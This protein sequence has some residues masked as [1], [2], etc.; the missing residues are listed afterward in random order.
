MTRRL[1]TVASAIFILLG[2]FVITAGL[3]LMALAPEASLLYYLAG[4]AT[5][6]LLGA[7]VGYP[8]SLLL[9]ILYRSRYP[10]EGAVRRRYLAGLTRLHRQARIVSLEGLPNQPQP[11]MEQLY[12]RLNDNFSELL[13]REAEGIFFHTAISQSGRLDGL[14][15]LRV[16]LRLVKKL[17]R[18]YHP[19]ARW[20]V[21]PALYVHVLDAALTPTRA[22]EIDYSAQIGPAIVG[23]SVVGA[24]PGGGLVSNIIAD[25]VI[26][27]SANALMTLRIGLLTRR[28][29]D[30]RLEGGTFDADKERR[31][32]N[33]EALDMLAGLVNASSGILSRTIWDAAKEHLKRI[34]GAT[35][36][37]LKTAVTK[38]VRGVTRKAQG[39][40]TGTA[41]D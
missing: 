1:I 7:A 11:F 31:A 23:A 36:E 26:Q 24:I 14:L 33:Q 15:L 13:L 27:G 16:Q 4:L 29:F 25:A 17:A 12:L 37:G 21:M 32:V 5:L 20:S 18:L 6:A 9:T 34:P 35:L 2:F 40:K 8:L 39:K 38:S 28:Y 10:V 3:Q 19:H 41:A 22:D 30:R